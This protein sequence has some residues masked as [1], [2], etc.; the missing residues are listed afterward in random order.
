MARR[1]IPVQ[2]R[3][4]GE[5]T[6]V[7]EQAYGY[8]AAH[9]KRLDQPDAEQPTPDAEKPAEQTSEPAPADEPSAT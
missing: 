5:K 6:T 2:H 7:S 3:T 8:F 9:Y 1:M 4:T